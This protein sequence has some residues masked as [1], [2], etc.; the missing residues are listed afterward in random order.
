[1]TYIPTS[2][3]IQMTIQ[4]I[5]QTPIPNLKALTKKLTSGMPK[6]Y[7]SY[8]IGHYAHINEI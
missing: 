3:E 5:A 8:M 7:V 2:I 4:F 6:N 1:M